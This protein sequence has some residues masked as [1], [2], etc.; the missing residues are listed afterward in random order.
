M[1]E[2]I[3]KVIEDRYNSIGWKVY[4]VV[5]RW[6]LKLLEFTRSDYK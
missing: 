3:E 1:S 4:Q 2:L 5:L 6:G